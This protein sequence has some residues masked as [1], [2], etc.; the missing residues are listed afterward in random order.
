MSSKPHIL[1]IEDE[2]QIHRFLAP[3]LEAGGYV[4]AGAQTG[5]AGLEALATKPPDAAILDLGLPDMDGA[6]VLTHARLF[7]SRPIIIISARVDPASKIQVLDLGADDYVQKPFDVGELMARLRAA[8]R[9]KTGVVDGK[10][11]VR[12]GDVEINLAKNIV[13]KNGVEVHLTTHEYEILSTLIGAAGKIMT[14]GHILRSAWGPEHADNVQYLRV[15]VQRLRAKLEAT[16][17][18]P[19]Y[20]LTE[21]RIGYRF[22]LPEEDSVVQSSASSVGGQGVEPNTTPS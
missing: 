5:R 10:L 18:R 2:P 17:S 14:H 4:Y 7:F 12:A 19:R 3:A 9:D 22:R 11:T 6:T 1:V 8:I 21:T 16:P 20:I 15:V 13:K